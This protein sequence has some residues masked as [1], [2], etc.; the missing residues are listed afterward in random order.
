M[1]TCL[2]QQGHQA[3]DHE[4]SFH[5]G[6]IE[7]GKVLVIRFKGMSVHINGSRDCFAIH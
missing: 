1:T 5:T 2:A 7:N 4:H 3:E 6:S